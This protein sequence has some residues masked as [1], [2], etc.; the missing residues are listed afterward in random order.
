MIISIIIQFV[1]IVNRQAWIFY[2][3]II[4]MESVRLI[5]TLVEVSLL[6]LGGIQAKLKT[7]GIF[8]FFSAKRRAVLA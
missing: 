3:R 7:I 6:S 5:K 1:L 4:I 8:P 2:V